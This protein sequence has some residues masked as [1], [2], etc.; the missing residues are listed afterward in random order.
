MFFAEL[1]SAED[2]ELASDEEI[3]SWTSGVVRHELR[4]SLDLTPE[5]GNLYSEQIFGLL[6]DE[7]ARATRFGRIEL[8]VAVTHAAFAGTPRAGQRFAVLPVLPPAL[9]PAPPSKDP[10]DRMSDIDILYERIISRSGRARRLR[11]LGVAAE[12]VAAEEAWVQRSVDVLFAN[13]WQPP[14][15]PAIER[16]VGPNR[17]TLM[18]LRDVLLE[19]VRAGAD[20]EPYLRAFGLRRKS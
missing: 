9:R 18:S 3:A 2:V 4:S 16:Y 13:A 17:R 7:T 1:L 10:V 15:A 8:S 11:Q 5:P 19:G 20:P 6:T 12:L 14:G